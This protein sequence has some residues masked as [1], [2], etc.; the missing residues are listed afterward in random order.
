M[1]GSR[2]LTDLIQV[3]IL[4]ILISIQRDEASFHILL[5]VSAYKYIFL[6]FNCF[7]KYFIMHENKI[8]ITGSLNV[9]SLV[10]LKKTFKTNL[11][12]VV[13]VRYM[14]RQL[15]LQDPEVGHCNSKW[16]LQSGS[17]C[18]QTVSQLNDSISSRE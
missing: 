9:K 16:Q 11:E 3:P 12:M 2:L 10:F 15:V 7:T 4:E 5:F 1:Y 18:L 17:C 8:V 13:S 14:L 6:Y